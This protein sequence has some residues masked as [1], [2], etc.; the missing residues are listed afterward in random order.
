MDEQIINAF[1]EG[2]SYPAKQAI[3][4]YALWYI[5][6]AVFLVSGGCFAIWFSLF[7]KKIDEAFD[8]PEAIIIAK[9][10]VAFIGFLFVAFNAPD[11]VASDAIAIH[12]L[13]TDLRG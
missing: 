3:D 10:I 1:F 8:E 12:G 2:L 6:Q 13:I 4:A 7:T 9:S 5:T 11:L